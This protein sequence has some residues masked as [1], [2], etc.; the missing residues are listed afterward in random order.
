[1]PITSLSMHHRHHTGAEIAVLIIWALILLGIVYAV[2]ARIR[3]KPPDPTWKESW[4]G[5]SSAERDRLAAAA[6]DGE[7]PA[8][9][10]DAAL[11][12][13]SARAQ[14]PYWSGRRLWDGLLFAFGLLLFL[15]MGFGW[16]PIAGFIG[17]L[18][19][20]VSSVRLRRGHKVFTTLKRAEKSADPAPDS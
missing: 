8:D 18:L 11:V 15:G 1:M 9:P 4:R 20:G 5:L 7:A 12:A 16:S 2:V 19:L 14:R 10:E 6:R 17:L 3:R 13:G